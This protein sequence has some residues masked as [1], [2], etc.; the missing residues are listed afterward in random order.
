MPHRVRNAATA[1]RLT[2]IKTSPVRAFHVKHLAA[3]WRPHLGA[4]RARAPPPFGRLTCALHIRAVVLPIGISVQIVAHSFA[5]RLRGCRESGSM[6]DKVRR[7][8][9]ATNA[10]L[11]RSSPEIG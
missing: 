9:L 8:A 10:H 2:R 1:H 4:F 7:E 6:F 5:C 11:C 3:H